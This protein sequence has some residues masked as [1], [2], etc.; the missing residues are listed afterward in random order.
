MIAQSLLQRLQNTAAYHLC[1]F[2]PTLPSLHSLIAMPSMTSHLFQALYMVAVGS[3]GCW[4]DHCCF[5]DCLKLGE[6]RQCEALFG[7]DTHAWSLLLKAFNAA[8]W[9][10]HSTPF[11]L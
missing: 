1:A 6:H 9:L 2:L 5:Q 11:A 8:N 4:M 10:G 3:R 7:G